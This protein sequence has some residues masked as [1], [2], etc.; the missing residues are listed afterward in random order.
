[1]EYQNYSGSGVGYGG[2]NY[3]LG[4]TMDYHHRAEMEE[5]P[6]R[7]HHPHAHH[8]Q[9]S[10]RR[11]RSRPSPG[12][13]Y[14]TPSVGHSSENPYQ[15]PYLP[16]RSA[17]LSD[18]P[19]SDN[20]SADTLTDSELPFPNPA[21]PLQNGKCALLMGGG[22]LDFSNTARLSLKRPMNSNGKSQTGVGL[23]HD[24]LID[25]F[26]LHTNTGKVY[27]P[28]DTPKNSSSEYKTSPG[29]T[30]SKK[31]SGTLLYKESGTM[32]TLRP[33]P[34]DPRQRSKVD[35]DDLIY[36]VRGLCTWRQLIFF[37][38]L[39]FLAISLVLNI[40]YSTGTLPLGSESS[41]SCGDG[42]GS[43]DPYNRQSGS[44]G[45]L[46]SAQH[47]TGPNHRAVPTPA[48]GKFPGI[49]YPPDGTS[50]G[51]ITIPTRLS[52]VVG[53]YSYWN[54]QFYQGEGA[55]VNWE[56][57][58]ARGASIGFYARRNALPSHTHYDFMEILRGFKTRTTRS[59]PPSVSKELSNFLEA[60]HW[61]LSLYNDDS[62]PQEVV[63][64][65]NISEEMTEG[66]P[67]GCSGNGQCQ[68]GHCHCNPGFGADDCSQ[69]VCPVLCSGRGEYADGFCVC[70]PGWKGKECSLR[71]DECEVSDCHGH[72]KCVNG[73][74]QCNPK[75]KGEFCEQVDCPHPSCN[76]HGLCVNGTCMC[77][78]GWRGVDCASTDKEA[79]QCLPDCS[80]HGEFNLESQTCTC[81]PKWTGED[82]SQE[83]CDINCGPNGV[84]IGTGCKCSEGWA[85]PL[86]NQRLCD[87]RC[88]EHGQCKN[89][90][91]LCV[92]GYNGKHCTLEG[93][94][95][96]CSGHGQCKA[97]MD[98]LWECKCHSG[99]AGSECAVMME[100]NCNDGKDN[101]KDGLT[102]CED[103]EC[104]GTAQCDKSQLC[105]AAKKPTDI[106]LRKQ[107]PAIT[108][109]FF[110]KMKFLI[111]EGSLQSYARQDAFNGSVFWSHF[112][113]SRSGVVRG[114]V[115]T[116]N[117]SGLM[118]V[119]VSSSSP[120]EPLGGF[121]LTQEDG[122]FD[123]MVN[124]GGAVTLQFGRSP[125]NSLSR[126]IFVPWNEVV[127]MDTVIMGSTTS[128]PV[129][130]PTQSCE[131]HDYE[132]MRP[133]VLATWKHGFQ[134]N[135][136]GTSAILIESQVV[137]ESIKIP[138]S[139]I[140]LMYHSS[141]G[142][143]YL[144]TIQLQLTP[145]TVTTALKRI[146]LRIT[147]E[148]V[149]FEKTFEA[150]PG[151]KFTY[152]W[153]R[154]N[155]YRQRVYGVTT[156]VVKVGFEY[157]NCGQVIWDVQSTTLSGH[158]MGISDIG[159]WNLDVHHRYN[160]HEGIIQK[161][162][163]SNIYLKH[164][165]RI[166]MPI[167]GN[168]HQRALDCHA[169]CNGVASKQKLLAP[170][171][172]A[173]A[174]DGTLFVGDFNLIRRI[175][176]DG[177]VHTIVKLNATRVSYRYHMAL[178]PVDN[179]LYISDPE[180]HQ[181][182]RVRN[183]ED[184]SDPEHNWEPVV[185]SGER[186]LP[187]DEAHC[188]D[189]ALA[190]DAKLAYPKGVAVSSDNVLFFADGTNI[191]KVDRDGIITTVIGNHQ[192]KAH[193]K[194]IPCEGTLKVEEVHLRWPTE[195]GVNP[196]DNSLYIIDDHMILMLTR[197]NRLRIIA[198]RPFHCP[199]PLGG[200]DADLAIHTALISPQSITF[201]SNG[202]LF[203]AESDSQRI[204]RVRMITTDGKVRHFAGAE[205]KCN[206][207]D[208]GCICY[209]D[210]HYLAST[211]KFNTISAIAMA[212]DGVLH[213][214]DQGNYRVR[215]VM[216]LIPQPSIGESRQY[217][218]YSPET[219]EIYIF[220]RFGQHISTKNIVTGETIYTFL[221]NVN[222][223]NGKLS[224]VTDSAGNKIQILRDYSSQVK[225]IENA[226]AQKF[227]LRMSRVRMLQ[228]FSSPEGYNYTFDYHGSTGLIKA[229]QDSSGRASVY[230]YDEFG[231]LTQTVS[232]TGQVVNLNFDLSKKGASVRVT[233]DQNAPEIYF[234]KGFSVTKRIGKWE[235]MT[236]VQDTNVVLQEPWG[237]V[238]TTESVPYNLLGEINPA[239]SDSFPVPGKQKTELGGDLMNR[240]EWRYVARKEG[241]GKNKQ[242]VQIDKKLR[243]NGD[244]VLMLEY[245]RE[246][247]S[248]LIVIDD[249]NVILNVTYDKTGRPLKW[250]PR[251]GFASVEVE[252]DRFGRLVGWKWDQLME[253]Y[254]YDR[255]GRL[256]KISYADGT[257]LSLT[258]KDLIATLP[259]KMTTAGGSDYLLEYDNAGA[260][261]SL[262]TPRGHIH[263][264][265]LSTSIGV[266]EY[267]Y[268]APSSREMYKIQYNDNGEVV[269]IVYPQGSGRVNLVYNRLGK[270]E[271]CVAGLRS[272]RFNYQENTGLM[273]VAEVAQ[274]AFELKTEYKYHG[275]ILKEQR[276]KFATKSGLD[277]VHLKFQ[278]DGN[279]RVSSVET[280]VNGKQIQT[281]SVKRNQN[282]GSLESI[283][284]LKIFGTPLQFNRTIVEDS[285]KLFVLT[286]DRDAV[287]RLKE[288]SII[289]KGAEVYKM[290]M[291]YDARGKLKHRKFNLDVRGSVYADN[292]MYDEDG[293]VSEVKGSG[294]WKYSYDENGNG[295]QVMEQGEKS[296][297]IYDSGD[298]VIQVGELLRYTYDARG[299]LVQRGAEKF[300]YD[301]KG[302]LIHAV[303]KDD[304][305]VWFF[306]DHLDRLISWKD[307][308]GNVTQ[309]IYAD[310]QHPQLLTHVH[311][312]VTGFNLLFVHDQNNHLV[313][314]VT[315][316]SHRFYV[317]T[318]QNGSPL[319]VFTPD[320]NLVKETH[321]SPFG[322]VIRDTAPDFYLPIDFHR[323]IVD[324]HTGIIIINGRAYDPTIGQWMV[325][326]W[327]ALTSSFHKPTDIFTYRFADNDP[328]TPKLW[329][330]ASRMTTLD[331]WL[332]LFGF[333][334]NQIF[335]KEYAKPPITGALIDS[336]DA[337]N[338]NPDFGV[339]S[340]LHCMGQT[341]SSSFKNV[342][343]SRESKL[344]PE[345]V[346]SWNL[347]PR[348][349][350]KRSGFGPGLLV[351]RSENGRALVSTVDNSVVQGV[352]TSVLN[353]SIFIEFRSTHQNSFYF[354]KDNPHKLR[355]DLEELKRLGGL[356]NTSVHDVENGIKELRLW[357]GDTSISVRYGTDEEEERGRLLKHAH[358]RAIERAWEEEKHYI[359]LGLDG[360]RP[361]TD[362][363]KDQLVNKGLV[364]GYRPSD[365]FSIHKYPHLADDPSNV[366]F[367]K[368]ARRK[369]RKSTKRRPPNS[370]SL[371]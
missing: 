361:W 314:M 1:M 11:S 324:K 256:S 16:G 182:I 226:Q 192:Q 194:P 117:G 9:Q 363:E 183:V 193:W 86:C 282:T 38:A 290:S 148:G 233:K 123:L 349:A 147:I 315:S 258:F 25:Q 250:I 83:L 358:R 293:H 322:K 345:R 211:S 164:R 203:V 23:N 58:V 167:M 61:F 52:H 53:P 294:H 331:S 34:P 151:I 120:L 12:V 165:P 292:V 234:I 190:R 195:L 10:L 199:I 127:I 149:L 323:G 288:Q 328:I 21:L 179:T 229:R 301:D 159:G 329:Q 90:I 84:C 40:L 330:V 140:Y 220:N 337:N 270:L 50:F 338:L 47:P 110:E 347:I 60:G 359:S 99:W 228:E 119:R 68:S 218:I 154:L 156:A 215:S 157:E 223:S 352:I 177:T 136:P 14:Q 241:R 222:M 295:I 133:V 59:S 354:V 340:G 152:A 132:G 367:Q 24:T 43:G 6:P 225:T 264:F 41:S 217:E 168:G 339:V 348:I 92:S 128:D 178:S 275:G 333:D 279:G 204:N 317:A 342:G 80:S 74:C 332:R 95:N 150:D 246:S 8:T 232:P 244:N 302:H 210:D 201:A 350:Y 291:Q 247:K 170:V 318:D 73:H 240:V 125:F 93:C 100:Q 284:D 79:L 115:V 280:E 286:S 213:I 362:E 31:T 66:C 20:G 36:K 109:S 114:R 35:E 309:F 146:H 216:A 346:F 227:N 267:Q 13:I 245:N 72:G 134:G 287:G 161:G 274:S 129:L 69:S 4:E 260:F 102:D 181:I 65:C 365:L 353:A 57:S 175:L 187:G 371:L 153:N 271:I 259:M 141:R 106:L 312:P 5:E 124:G 266:Y 39:L 113:K 326:R 18:S 2:G 75:F 48:G 268:R 54:M 238:V 197:D 209:E 189:E 184:F 344:S 316:K 155:V 62:D 63:F 94:P 42:L 248:E 239:L 77:K 33:P 281:Y 116:P 208:R 173:T 254:E 28:S 369:R 158:D 276:E 319:S 202:D 243:I 262:T 253:T 89:G 108:A 145:E 71:H 357:G 364:H 111:E 356:F 103:P 51:Q 278:Y 325:P 237:Q 265:G 144:S 107:P 255:A 49:N 70:N 137:Q 143:G 105:V 118:G 214:A 336:N 289:I 30:A 19:T 45:T 370:R 174:S 313:S 44:N 112:N 122:W 219:Q 305:K 206:C 29:S 160:F 131:A 311:Y 304:Y 26:V 272:T 126:T 335:G 188:G 185:G 198:G 166:I 97:N 180:S 130:V 76:G 343:F 135:C 81:Q 299:F 169:D 283:G 303:K 306:Y 3:G 56:L 310:P 121:T 200:Y 207:L 269:S 162:D 285:S 87:K 82:C 22:T 277:N 67:N 64:V 261:Q 96:S 172:L 139:G 231:R 85:G 212:P 191:R 46:Q 88:A 308:K 257:S 296:S 224:S 230:S 298:R 186:C 55:Y 221:Y 196:V 101:D 320:G 37:G 91:C 176:V 297:L 263:S 252:H 17:G 205:S 251:G 163:G 321:R 249:R 307:D 351:S 242:I 273:K 15:Q 341:T 236:S 78:K 235:Q 27:I 32:G 7:G 104:C 142:T 171:A 355:D 360:R 138:G 327:Q 368:D 98:G 366:I 334:M 300:Q